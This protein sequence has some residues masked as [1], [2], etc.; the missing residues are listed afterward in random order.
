MSNICSVAPTVCV[1][2][3]YAC[4]GVESASAVVGVFWLS[5]AVVADIF[6]VARAPVG[7]GF[8][9]VERQ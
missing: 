3:R 1:L 9:P 6:C 4:R 5:I 2:P 7:S 8:P